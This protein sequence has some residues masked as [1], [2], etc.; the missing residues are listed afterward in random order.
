M[1]EAAA[2]LR[3]KNEE[4]KKAWKNSDEYKDKTRNYIDWVKENYPEWK[5]IKDTAD[6]AAQRYDSLLAQIDG[7]GAKSL[8]DA[9]KKVESALD[10]L[11][12]SV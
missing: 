1:R 9:R 3:E 11:E 2:K 6:T 4:V 5:S 7:P 12:P 8:K 10:D